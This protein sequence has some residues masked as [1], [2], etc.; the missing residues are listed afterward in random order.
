MAEQKQTSPQLDKAQRWP[1]KRNW[2]SCA[3]SNR[4][5]VRLDRLGTVHSGFAI[6]MHHF[7]S[8]SSPRIRIVLLYVRSTRPPAEIWTQGTKVLLP[9]QALRGELESRSTPACS[10]LQISSPTKSI[11]RLG[12]PSYRLYSFANLQFSLDLSN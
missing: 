9:L 7:Q 3:S 12:I 6:A 11:G 4:R 2:R 5:R 1:H 8:S 10:S